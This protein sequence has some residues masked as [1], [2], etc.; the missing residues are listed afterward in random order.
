MVKKVVARQVLAELVRLPRTAVKTVAE[1]I[2]AHEIE[3]TSYQE[4]QGLSWAAQARLHDAMV[5]AAAIRGTYGRSIQQQTKGEP[6][7]TKQKKKAPSRKTQE[8]ARKVMV[9]MVALSQTP[10]KTVA[11]FIVAQGITGVTMA[12]SKQLSQVAQGRL[13]A[14]LQKAYHI[15]RAAKG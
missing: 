15:R 7:T 14:A 1:F 11:E 5:T 8:A 2:H 9:E 4:T 6:F 12:E 13:D 3:G 10:V